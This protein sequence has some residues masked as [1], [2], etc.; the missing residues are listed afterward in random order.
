[1]FLL[2][3]SDIEEWATEYTIE[4]NIAIV[5]FG[6]EARI[7]QQLTNDYNKV[8]EAVGK[9]NTNRILGREEMNNSCCPLLI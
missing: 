9:I 2:F 1:M 7:L 3:I 8:R 5:H 6:S 4:E